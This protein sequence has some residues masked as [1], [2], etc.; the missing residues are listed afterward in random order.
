MKISGYLISFF[1]GAAFVYGA[2]IVDK[3]RSQPVPRLIAQGCLEAGGD[4]WAMEEDDFPT[5]CQHI[6]RY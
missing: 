6:E 1:L 3:V 2:A 4:L 5:L